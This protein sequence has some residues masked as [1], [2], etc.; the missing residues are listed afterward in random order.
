MSES[1]AIRV[2]NLDVTIKHKKILKELNLSVE[3]GSF[4]G[5]IGPNGAGKTTLFDTVLG[6]R[7]PT[8]GS[9]SLLGQ[10][11]HPRRPELLARIGVQPQKT[12]FFPKSRLQEHLQ[13]VAD[14]YGAPRTS[15]EALIDALGLGSAAKTKVEDL[16]GGESQRLAVAS[17]IVHQ[18]DIVFL[19]EPTAGLD[20]A[21]RQNL[22][23]LLQSSD[24]LD[25]TTLYT[26]HYLDEA[27]RLCDTVS[28]VDDGRIL[29]TASP[30]RL[31]AEANLGATILL[32]AALH[33]TDAV[34]GLPGIDAARVTGDGVEVRTPDTATA[35]ASLAEAGINTSSAQVHN[36]R[37]EDVYLQLTGKDYVA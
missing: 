36:G 24:V 29:R 13:A 21:A 10:S 12:A 17:A 6:F 1:L 19:D 5:I 16:S 34:K 2:A 31:I 18:P 8:S 11:P 33:Q 15:V 28:I 35:F 3:E 9:V 26:T 25:M 22:V 37:L 20:P 4:H 30:S 7:Q 32:P 23:H 14:I 27:E